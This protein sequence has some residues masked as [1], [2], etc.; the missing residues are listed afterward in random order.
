MDIPYLSTYWTGRHMNVPTWLRTV[1]IWSA[2]CQYHICLQSCTRL[3]GIMT[4]DIRSRGLLMIMIMCHG[5]KKDA[6]QRLGHSSRQTGNPSC[7]GR[8]VYILLPLMPEAW[9]SYLHRAAACRLVP[10][11]WELVAS[12]PNQVTSDSSPITWSFVDAT[13]TLYPQR[14]FN[15]LRLIVS[16]PL[17]KKRKFFFVFIDF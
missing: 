3:R 12:T 11:I 15:N 6:R 7:R 14:L 10:F 16:R 13:R 2:T 9:R 17:Y 5:L 8:P 4:T 1:R